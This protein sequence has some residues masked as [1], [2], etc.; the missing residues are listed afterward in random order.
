MVFIHKIIKTPTSMSTK[1]LNMTQK[2]NLI[3]MILMALFLESRYSHGQNLALQNNI[4]RNAHYQGSSSL[5]NEI[6]MFP[7]N[8]NI[9]DYS[10]NNNNGTFINATLSTDRFGNPNSAYSFNGINQYAIL[11]ALNFTNELTISVW[12]IFPQIDTAEQAIITKYDADIGSGNQTTMRSFKISKESAQYGSQFDF[13]TTD[14]GTGNWHLSSTTVPVANQWYHVTGTFNNGVSKI[15]VNGVLENTHVGSYS[16][17]NSAV[18]ILCGATYSD[19]PNP[20]FFGKVV[21][22]D[23]HFFE[24]SLSDSEVNSLFQFG[25]IFTGACDTLYYSTSNNTWFGQ[26]IQSLDGNIVSVGTENHVTNWTSGDIFLSKYDTS[27]NLIWSRKFY[28]GGGMDVAGGVLGTSDGGYLIHGAFGNSNPAGNFS[29]GYII[30][31]DGSGIQQWA[32]TLTGQSYGDNYSSTAVENSQGEFICYGHVQNH[33]G[34]SSYATRITKLSATGSIIWSNCVALNPDL[35]GGI[36]KL[37]SSDTYISSFNNSNGVVEL[38]K[39]DDSG[40][41]IGL[42]NYQFNNQQ[43]SGGGVKK[44]QTGGFFLTGSYNSAGNQKNAFIAKFDDAMNFLWEASDSTYAENYFLTMTEDTQ[45]NIFCTARINDIGQPGDLL[46]TQFSSNGIFQNKGIFGGPSTDDFAQG[47]LTLANGDI[48]CS[49]RSD[50]QGLLV[51]FCGL[52]GNT[53]SVSE[54]NQQSY[55]LSAFPN[56]ANEN[57]YL[58]FYTVDLMPYEISIFNIAGQRVFNEI[59]SPSSLGEQM[60]NIQVKTFKSGIYFIRL[61]GKYFNLSQKIVITN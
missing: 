27:F 14:N 61:N 49:G 35:N 60:L 45:G 58:N 23:I 4:H 7:F 40:N 47:I 37:S 36:T 10:G 30:K 2:F 26:V 51:K 19:F 28:V 41:Q 54:L 15:Y 59:I 8:G 43:Y 24:C 21:L 5:C 55:Q 38:R 17:Y 32:Q 20:S 46:V 11:P 50:S 13:Q 44:C 33:S 22:D 29:A 34:C 3:A 52:G 53:T 6:A 9:N 18:N 12:V 48:I 1:A 31:T 25:N 42:I 39:W 56:P 16:I 57:I